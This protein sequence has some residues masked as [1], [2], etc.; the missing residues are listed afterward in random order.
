M[1]VF[2]AHPVHLLFHNC[3]WKSRKK[4]KKI[5]DSKRSNNVEFGEIPN[6]LPFY[7][8]SQ[9]ASKVQ[10][11]KDEVKTNIDHVLEFKLP[12]SWIV[13]IPITNSP[14][15]CSRRDDGQGEAGKR[16]KDRFRHAPHLVENVRIANGWGPFVSD[17][18]PKP[19]C[20]PPFL[21]HRLR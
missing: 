16:G 10:A 13:T 5:S 12:I 11:F 4:N 1:E 19:Y 18:F 7:G 21:E 14:D 20:N 2:G 6:Q 8:I 17:K 3:G 15:L 9:D